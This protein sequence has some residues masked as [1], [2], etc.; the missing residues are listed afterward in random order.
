MPRAPW[1]VHQQRAACRRGAGCARRDVLGRIARDGQHDEAQE[2]LVD[3]AA[4]AHGLN[5]TG[6]VLCTAA[7]Q[8]QGQPGGPSLG[9]LPARLPARRAPRAGRHSPQA[10]T[11]PGCPAVRASRAKQARPKLL[12]YAAWDPRPAAPTRAHR[13]NQGDAQQAGQGAAQA[14]RGDLLR[15]FALQASRETPPT[16]ISE[17]LRGDRVQFSSWVC[18]GEASRREAAGVGKGRRACPACVA[19]LQ[20]CS[21]GRALC[22]PP[23]FVRRTHRKVVC[24]RLQLEEE[25]ANVSAAQLQGQEG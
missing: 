12:W 19:P 21:P 13:H 5:S 24:M 3:A 1:C 25:V 15:L 4:L 10:G 14:Q 8:G 2:G 20:R 22:P 16:G 17:Q 11:P 23:A 6:Q 7:G 9:P 18:Q